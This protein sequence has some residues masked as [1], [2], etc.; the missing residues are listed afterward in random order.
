MI[1][2]LLYHSLKET[3][4]IYRL[5]DFLFFV[6]LTFLSFFENFKRAL[7][8]KKK[9]TTLELCEFW[10]RLNLIFKISKKAGVLSPAK[11][12]YQR[13]KLL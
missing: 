11:N 12:L 6:R 4:L 5:N 3:D 2:F 9:K 13:L 1:L 8:Q 7:Y 10:G